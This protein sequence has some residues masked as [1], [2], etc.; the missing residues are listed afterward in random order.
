M[1]HIPPCEIG[2]DEVAVET[3]QLLRTGCT[4]P[5]GRLLIT[6]IMVRPTMTGFVRHAFTAPKTL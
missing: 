3:K 2:L 5:V 4:Q 1:L 6:S